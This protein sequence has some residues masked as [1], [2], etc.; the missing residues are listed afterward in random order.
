MN[1]Q[2]RI[3]QSKSIRECPYCRHIGDVVWVHGHGQCANCKINI[4]E[5]CRGE[6]C[7]E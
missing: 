2:P 3:P 1:N 6:E 7:R 5:C 4:D